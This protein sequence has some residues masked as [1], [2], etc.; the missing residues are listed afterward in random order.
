M[1]PTLDEFYEVNDPITTNYKTD[2]TIKRSKKSK[3]YQ[4][5]KNRKIRKSKK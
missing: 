4:K 2:G 5:S 3:R 1:R